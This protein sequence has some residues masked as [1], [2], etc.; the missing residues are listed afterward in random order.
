MVDVNFPPPPHLIS[1]Q[2]LFDASELLLSITYVMLK[3]GLQGKKM[4]RYLFQIREYQGWFEANIPCI[5]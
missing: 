3:Y 5:T 1:R 4:T 2:G